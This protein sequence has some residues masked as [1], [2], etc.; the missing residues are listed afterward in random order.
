MYQL[1][2]IAVGITTFNRPRFVEACASSLKRAAGI[3]A[4]QL[5]LVDDHSTE[6][7]VHFLMRCFGDQAQ[8]EVND[9]NSGGADFAIRNMFVRLCR[10]Q[11][12]L[13]LLLDS[14][15]IVAR[16][17]FDKALRLVSS[18]DGFFSVFNTPS[19]PT[20]GSRGPF[21]LKDYVGSA[22][23]LW[24]ADIAEAMLA[25]VPPGP[26]F[27]WRFCDYLRQAS[28]AVLAVKKSLVQHIGFAEGQ[29]S[30][31][32]G[33]DI[34]SGFTD[35]DA[36]NAYIMQHET[37]HALTNGFTRLHKELCIQQGELRSAQEK[38]VDLESRITQLERR[39]LWR[40]I[41]RMAVK[42]RR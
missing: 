42:Q 37:A 18:S 19:H 11:A 31:F 14:D 5:V 32:F 1:S 17:I 26:R 7:D 33:G 10:T 15:L 29:N 9:A 40:A 30:P 41:R 20:V 25:S 13:L 2:D 6:Y 34:G 36:F 16:D 28:K 39:G 8:I 35:E 27:D 4:V 12:K 23:T 21:V 38:I 22:G 24:K 3:E